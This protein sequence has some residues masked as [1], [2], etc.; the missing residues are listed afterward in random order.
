MAYLGKC[1]IHAS[2][3]RIWR[4]LMNFGLHPNPC[5]ITMTARSAK[6]RICTV[7]KNG[8]FFNTTEEDI[9]KGIHDCEKNEDLFF[10][11]AALRDDSDINQWFIYDNRSWNDEN[12]TRCWFI[13][14]QESIEVDMAYDQLYA[15]CE[16]ATEYELILHFNGDDDDEIVINQ[17]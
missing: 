14:K 10:A 2:N 8:S 17:Q 9:S 3:P 12:P 15:D 5:G 11:L 4:K 16:K 7:V 1:A 6:N 13:C